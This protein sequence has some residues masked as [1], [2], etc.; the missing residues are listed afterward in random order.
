VGRF[1][2]RLRP[3]DTELQDQ[4]WAEAHRL[5]QAKT[6]LMEAVSSLIEM[7]GDNPNAFSWTK[8]NIKGLNRTTDGQAV[9]GLVGMA[10]TERDASHRTGVRLTLG[11]HS[12]EEKSLASMPIADAFGVLA[13]NE[14]RLLDALAAARQLAIDH[15]GDGDGGVAL[16][17]ALS[18]LITHVIYVDRFVG[19]RY[20]ND[21]SVVAT[22]AAARVVYEHLAAS[23]GVDTRHYRTA[24]VSWWPPGD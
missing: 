15:R 11:R 9:L 4:I 12:S 5:Y 1:I 14:P 18:Q 24:S 10:S 6:P 20:E 3:G 8:R 21:A 2:T 7:A 17:E 16:R 23:A 19:N 13:K 22:E